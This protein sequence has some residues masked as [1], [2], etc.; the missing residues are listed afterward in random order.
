MIGQDRKAAANEHRYEEEVEEMA[1]ADPERKAV[2]PCEVAGIY[3]GDGRNVG[4]AGHGHLYPCCGHQRRYYS[5][6]PIRIEGR[7]Q[8]R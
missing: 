1:V 7:I 3:Q 6:T 8:R 4:Q 2:R 5:R